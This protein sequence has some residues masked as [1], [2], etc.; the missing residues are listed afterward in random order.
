MTDCMVLQSCVMVTENINVTF[1]NAASPTLIWAGT[2]L[3]YVDNAT[4]LSLLPMELKV[5]MA[6]E[7]R[8]RGVVID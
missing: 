5:K 7:R 3:D 1:P 2:S 8:G 4:L 6:I